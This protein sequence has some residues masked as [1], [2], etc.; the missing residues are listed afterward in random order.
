MC[1]SEI[2]SSDNDDDVVEVH[3]TSSGL[4][5]TSDDLVRRGPSGRLCVEDDDR[6]Y[7]NMPTLSNIETYN[8]D[9][10]S[11]QLLT[12]PSP[13][14]EEITIEDELVEDDEVIYLKS[15]IY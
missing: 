2:V 10:D 14:I 15:I 5:Y 7:A 6:L 8:D 11:I 3:Y 4:S 12:I 1:K 9:D 13:Q